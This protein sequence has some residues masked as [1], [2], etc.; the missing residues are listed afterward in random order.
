MGIHVSQTFL[1]YLLIYLLKYI[2]FYFQ[3]ETPLH[4]ACEKSLTN[5]VIILLDKGSNPN[6]QTLRVESPGGSLTADLLS[7]SDTVPVSQ[8]TPLHLALL[9]GH[10]EIVNVFLQ[11]KCKFILTFYRNIDIFIVI[12]DGYIFMVGFNV[13]PTL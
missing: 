1:V 6:A 13:T 3:G 4:I 7:E 11:F 2:F 8:Q 12:S 5:L 9:N 10:S